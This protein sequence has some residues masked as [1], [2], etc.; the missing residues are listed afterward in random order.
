MDQPV[1]IEFI[2]DSIPASRSDELLRSWGYDLVAEYV[3][4]LQEANLDATP[5]ILDLATGSGRMSAVLTRLGFSVVTGDISDEKHASVLDRVTPAFS[6]RVEHLIFNMKMLPFPSDH[7]KNI[8][9]LNTLHELDEPRVCV[10]ELIRVHD[11]RGTLVLGDFNEL[12]FEVMQRLHRAVYGNDHPQGFLKMAELRSVLQESYDVIHDVV[13]PL[14]ISY[15][16]AHK[17]TPA[18]T[19]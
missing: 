14:N 5:L 4:I 17:K 3:Q 10:S 11:P 1:S 2:V 9:C 12:G 15:I 8:V 13:T 18:A 16:A 6:D 7:F 19:S